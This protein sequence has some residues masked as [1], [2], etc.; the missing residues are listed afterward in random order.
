MREAI[1]GGLRVRITGGSD[2][3]GGRKG[4]GPTVVLLHGFGAPGDD[5]VPLWRVLDVPRE[6]R[7]VFPAAPLPL[8]M[9]YGDARAWWLID[10][11]RIERAQLRLAFMHHPLSDLSDLER[12]M[13][14]DLLLERCHFVLRGPNMTGT[15]VPHEIRQSHRRSEADDPD[16]YLCRFCPYR[17]HCHRLEGGAA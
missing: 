12:R 5:L 4:E 2:R 11:E 3:E 17:V 9:G 15:D 1:F 8:D 7:F 14:Q 16:H 10:M 13:I 6:V